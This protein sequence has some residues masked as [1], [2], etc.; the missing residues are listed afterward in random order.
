[1][2]DGMFDEMFDRSFDGTFDACWTINGMFD[3]AFD[4]MI[5]GMFARDGGVAA[6]GADM[7]SCGC[8]LAEM[9]VGE[10]FF[11]GESWCAIDFRS[12]V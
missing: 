1:M 10:P 9:A 7:W 6:P 11:V 4:G 8:I 5:A 12:S 3:G 2:F